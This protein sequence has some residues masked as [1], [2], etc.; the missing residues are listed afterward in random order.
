[1]NITFLFFKV[2]CKRSNYLWVSFLIPVEHS[3]Y[4]GQLQD[5][6]NFWSAVA[7]IWQTATATHNFSTSCQSNQFFFPVLSTSINHALMPSQ[8]T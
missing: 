4:Y 5:L 7:V 1:M 8:I 6:P 2:Q 3:I